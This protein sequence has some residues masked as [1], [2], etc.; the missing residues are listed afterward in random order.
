MS[1]GER[2]R[3]TVEFE[4]DSEPMSGRMLDEGGRSRPFTGWLGLAAAFGSVL[5]KE[6]NPL[7]ERPDPRAGRSQARQVSKTKPAS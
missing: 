1:P 6:P 3:V 7:A 5:H 2:T 4:S